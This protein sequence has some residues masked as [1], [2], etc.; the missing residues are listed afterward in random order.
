MPATATIEDAA[1]VNTLATARAVAAIMRKHGWHSVIVVSDAFNVLRAESMLRDQG[2]RVS[3]AAANDT[4]YA[5][6]EIV[7]YYSR[8]DGT[9]LWCTRPSGWCIT[10]S[11][12]GSSRKGFVQVRK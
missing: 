10:C 1:S 5:G 11:G 9:R 6:I 3:A 8:E 4:Y 2:L 7:Y 12:D